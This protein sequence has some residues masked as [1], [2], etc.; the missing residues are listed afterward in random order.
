[1]RKK[2]H[3]VPSSTAKPQEPGWNA[4]AFAA[5]AAG[6]M[7][8]LN[9]PL[10]AYPIVPRLDGHC[11]RADTRMAA[12]LV[13]VVDRGPLAAL[14]MTTRAAH[15]RHHPGQVSFPGG[16][17]EEGDGTALDAALR[18]AE[19][20][21]GLDRALVQPLGQLAA[22]QTGTGFRIIPVLAI[23]RPGFTLRLDKSEVG[24]AFEVPLEFLMTAAN[25]QKHDVE[26]HGATRKF[27]SIPYGERMIWGATAAILRYMQE[28]FY[29]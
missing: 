14:L 2:D 3:R 26:V 22:H 29:E 28:V 4:G 18:E 19:E 15:L 1:M 9:T 21:I 24:D 17:I 10:D 11:P 25:Y 8:P 6:K 20:E 27:H 23:V 7:L 5:R 13:P 16:K 12:V